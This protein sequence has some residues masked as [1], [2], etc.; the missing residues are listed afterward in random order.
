MATRVGPAT[1]CT[2]PLNRP[3]PKT[4]FGTKILHVVQLVTKL[5]PLKCSKQF[6]GVNFGHLRPK[7]KIEEQRFVEGVMEN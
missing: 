2:V 1:L 4:P 3:L 6:W 5:W 7:S